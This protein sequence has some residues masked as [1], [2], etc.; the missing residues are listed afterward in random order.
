MRVA[1]F[2]PFAP[3]ACGLY[4]A[5]RDFVRADRLAGRDAEL[6]AVPYN[7]MEPVVGQHDDRGKER[8]TGKTWE[9]CRD[10]DVF[11]VHG[12][13]VDRWLAQTSTPVVVA[14]H[15]R[16][17][18][19]FR[20]E[21]NGKSN[22]FSLMCEFAM[23]ER[24]KVMLTMWA[25]HMPYWSR[26]MPGDR[27]ETT[28]H[29]PIDCDMFSP[30]GVTIDIPR[31][32]RGRRNLLICDSW[33][34]DVDCFEAAVGAIH[35]AKLVPGLKVHFFGVEHK[36]GK[37]PQCWEHI[38]TA[39]RNMNSLGLV[40]GR[41]LEIA[42]VYRSMDLLLSPHR[43]GVRTIGEALASGIQVVAESGCRYTDYTAQ[44]QDPESVAAK[45]EHCIADLDNDETAMSAN[46]R[47]TA[48]SHFSLNQ[49]GEKLGPIYEKA[50]SLP[51]SC[52]T[53]GEM[54]ESA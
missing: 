41:I 5:A 26:F 13:F 2:S 29:P 50:L 39:L 17:Q 38:F 15:G 40:S 23:Y 42:S 34:D 22:T 27:L 51:L 25:E 44:M 30:H 1:H 37:P 24:V 47:M 4:E 18:A 36:E 20:P 11:V 31:E 43:I 7:G 12:T 35:A 8:V 14:L 19:C 33:R 6:C 21:Q 28:D 49:F 53:V 48:V 10:A 54:K 9:E 52:G 45:I 3:G 46:A 32:Q 16:P